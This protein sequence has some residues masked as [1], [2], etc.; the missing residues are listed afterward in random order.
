MENKGWWNETDEQTIRDE[1]RVAVMDAL[2]TAENRP[3]PDISELFEDV[4]KEI[5][6]NLKRQKAELEAHIE[7]YPDH[8]NAGH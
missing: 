7:K 1:E 4:Y 6:E 3:K 5:P 8:Y 2:T